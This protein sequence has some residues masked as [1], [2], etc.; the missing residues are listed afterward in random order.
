M[1]LSII[2]VITD[3]ARQKLADMLISGRSF[4]VTHF[5]TGSGGHDTGNPTVALTPD[6]TVIELPKQSFGPKGLSS[7][8]LISAFC[9]RFEGILLSTE[10]IGELSNIGL[11][12]TVIYSPIPADPVVGTKFLFAVGNFPLKVKTD[13]DELTIRVTLQ[14]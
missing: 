11:I 4:Q 10:A 13:T 9:P 6:P 12:A 8:T 14:F 5:V 7:A 3:S 2:A 1:A